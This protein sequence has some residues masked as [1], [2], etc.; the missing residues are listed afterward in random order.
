M[1]DGRA[2]GHARFGDDERYGLL[3]Q[4]GLLDTVEEAVIYV[5][6]LLQSSGDE[7]LT[8]ADGIALARGEI[9]AP[10]TEFSHPRAIAD[11]NFA[12]ARDTGGQ[13]YLI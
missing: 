8:E 11:Y 6:T 2:C 7:V 9:G 4:F 12:P 13:A 5:G 3:A 10:G 1:T